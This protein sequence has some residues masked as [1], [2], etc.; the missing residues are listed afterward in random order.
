MKWSDRISAKLSAI[1]DK[2]GCY[3]M[4]DRRGK[5]IYV[6]KASS[7][8][9]RLRNYFGPSALRRAD[10]KLRGLIRSIEDFDILIARNEAEAVLT[11]GKLIKE[12]KPFYNVSFKD[13]KRFLLVRADPR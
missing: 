12:Y 2:P 8:R 6:G 9:Q 4:R 13:D 10:A 11:E 1:P 3:I 5:I 7:L